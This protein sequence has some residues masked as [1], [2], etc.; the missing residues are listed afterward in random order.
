MRY[1]F[2]LYGNNKKRKDIG[3]TAVEERVFIHETRYSRPVMYH[4]CMDMDEHRYGKGE[5]KDES[6]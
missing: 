3:M 2:F 5:E 1:G 6:T 4:R